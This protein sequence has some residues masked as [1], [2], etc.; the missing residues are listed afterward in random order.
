MIAA[1]MLLAT[2]AAPQDTVLPLSPRAVAMLDRFPPPRNSD[3][4][5]SARFSRDSVWLGEQVELVTATW[6]RRDLRERLRRQP[7]LRAPAL[8]G[9]WSAPASVSPVLARTERVDGVVYDLYVSHQ[10]LF[11][12]GAGAIEAPPAVL[13]YAVPSSTS[14]FAPEERRTVS[15]RSARLVVREIPAALAGALG[16]GPTAG[17]LRAHW[18][19][20]NA[21]FAAGTP[22][23]VVLAVTGEGNVSL[24]PAPEIAWPAGVRVYAEPTE[25]QVRRPAGVVAGAK[26]FTFTLVVDSAG[27]V[28]LPR[29]RYPYFDPV[30]AGVVVATASPVTLAVQAAGAAAR[31]PVP[32]SRVLATPIASQLVRRGWALLLLI[33]LLPLV[34]SVTRRR[35]R[36]LPRSVPSS[37]STEELLR[38][39]L[40]QAGE[41]TPGRVEVALRRQG[42]PREDAR[43]VRRWL[44]GV[45]RHRWAADHPPPPP[46]DVAVEVVRRLRDRLRPGTV[47]LGLLLVLAMPLRAQWDEAIARYRDGDGP[48]AERLF[49]A[50]VTSHPVSP[51]AWLDLGAARWMAG[52]DVGSA[53]AW[54]Q[55]VQLAPRD[56]RFHDALD[57]VPG[58]P[59]EVRGRAPTLPFSRDELLL[60]AWVSW[61]VAWG[62]WRRHRRVAWGAAVLLVVAGGVA[63]ARI[64]TRHDLALVR[65]GMA[66]RVSPVPG[67]PVL[68][69]AP[70]WAVVHLERRDGRWWLVHLENGRR[71]WIPASGVAPLSPLD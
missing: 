61:L 53:A 21:T 50:V 30:R 20:P 68:A 40:G 33:A 9:L 58:L 55:G 41:A 14:F 5:V 8:S 52:D 51:D 45:E 4:S 17:N 46:D 54:L 67:T 69:E 42:V 11:P 18:Q 48:G 59:R 7:S 3:V 39:L 31:S 13:T 35:R 24:W 1:L 71:G 70:A 60:I 34:I 29:V 43:A 22:V 19:V 15:S 49:T 65:P 44:E 66:L 6:F 47:A 32:A 23:T 57:R 38:R 63:V 56:A 64:G 10:T 27:A 62:A 12:L 28:T 2:L 37:G 25:E 36:P 26:Q 16:S